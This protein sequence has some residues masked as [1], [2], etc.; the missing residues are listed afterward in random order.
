MSEL[1]INLYV[2]GEDALI[3]R[4]KI[5]AD[6]VCGTD[7]VVEQFRLWSFVLCYLQL[8]AE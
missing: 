1:K 7:E 8:N 4:G 6:N 2:D 5:L 3:T